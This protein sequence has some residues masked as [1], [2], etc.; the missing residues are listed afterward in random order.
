M[1]IEL[2]DVVG[3]DNIRDQKKVKF[4]KTHNSLITAFGNDFTKPEYTLGVI[5]VIRDPRNVITSVKN[6]Y[7]L[8]TLS[9]AKQFLFNEKNIITMS[10]KQKEKYITQNEYPLPTVLGSWKTHYLSWKNM[11]KNYLLVKYENLIQNPLEEFRKISKYFSQILSLE[12]TNDQIEEAV[13]LSSFEKLK[14]MEENYGFTESSYNNITGEKNTFFNLGPK[15]DWTKILDKDIADEIS[16]K[17][18][19]EMKELGYL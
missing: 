3:Q 14:K 16:V 9:I 19:P 10:E 18:E 17:F 15:N 4:L 2:A 5:Y 13:K 11:K 6:H 1:G 8:D 7:N 12:F